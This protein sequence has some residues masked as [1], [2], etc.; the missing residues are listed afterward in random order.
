M[1]P[2]LRSTQSSP[3]GKAALHDIS[4]NVTPGRKAPK[5]TKCGQPRLGHPRSGCP[6]ADT[7]NE[8]ADS[9]PTKLKGKA[10]QENLSEVFG[11]MYLE[12]LAP[13]ADKD[14]HNRPSTNTPALQ[15]SET[16]TSLSTSAEEL[17]CDLTKPGFFSQA[18]VSDND[19]KESKA[20]GSTALI[21]T[22]S[23]LKI[24]SGPQIL[25][26]GTL[27]APSWES[28]ID[29]LSDAVI[30]SDASS[31]RTPLKKSTLGVQT[32]FRASDSDIAPSPLHHSHSSAP[33]SQA[34]VPARSLAQS[35][36]QEQR[37]LFLSS[38]P[39]TSPMSV[40][41][42][43]KDMESLE[44][45]ARAAKLHIRAVHSEDQNEEDVLLVIGND[46]SAVEKLAGE[47][48]K[49]NKGQPSTTANDICIIKSAETKPTS[50]TFRA[51][52]S[53]AIVG[54]VGT[55]AGLAFS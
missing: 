33:S 17:L 40:F 30:S 47:L 5:C 6:N 45:S 15:Q 14:R 22:P 37:G 32:S 11:S 1:P 54:A 41:V 49:S 29:G 53:G 7:Q 25:M 48:A 24:K 28:S 51:V 43:K 38:I 18:T 8:D 50:S 20:Q 26:P 35:H 4:P 21:L 3:A 36:T 10:L 2:T 52:A 55:W 46:L 44:A 13:S 9:G 34:S 16:L 12:P 27:K 39:Q 42:H 19:N 31:K 23:Q